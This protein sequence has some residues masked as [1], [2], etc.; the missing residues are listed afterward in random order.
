MEELRSN[1]RGAIE[2]CLSVPVEMSSIQTDDQVIE[3]AL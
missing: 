2:G 3:L 1:L